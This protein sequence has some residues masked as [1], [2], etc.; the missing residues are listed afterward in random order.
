M[1]K[2]REDRVVGEPDSDYQRTLRYD[3]GSRLH[4]GEIRYVVLPLGQRHSIVCL[5]CIASIPGSGD[6]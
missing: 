3:V 6:K 2:L 1:A 4:L 5:V